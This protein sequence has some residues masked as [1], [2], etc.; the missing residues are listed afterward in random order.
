MK[1]RSDHPAKTL[2]KLVLV[3]YP[4]GS[5]VLLIDLRSCIY[6]FECKIDGSAQEALDQMEAGD[7]VD[8]FTLE[9]KPS[10]LLD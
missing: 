3:L 2:V 1:N 8:R 4:L 6:L 10:C 9:K 7:Y 5:V